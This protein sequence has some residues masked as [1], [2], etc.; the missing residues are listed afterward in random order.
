[1]FTI[2]ADRIGKR[3]NS[4]NVFKGLSF[5]ANTG[6]SIAV[7]GPNGS[8]KTTLLEII[9]GI[10]RPTVGEIKYRLDGEEIKRDVFPSL[11]GFSSPKINPYNELTGSENIQFALK[12]RK[13]ICTDA[14]LNR[15]LE[16]FNLKKEKNKS[17]RY[18]SSG[19]KQRLRLI[20]AVLHNPQILLLDEPGSNLDRLGKDI[21]YTYLD[22]VRSKKIIVI[23]TN[24]K[25][26]ANLCN[27]RL[28]LGQ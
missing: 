12:S 22:S 19:M 7:T 16:M 23:A 3:F 10:Q 26:E 8:G 5:T 11:L 6:S 25:E 9:A 24:E 18:Y 15:L 1:M 20:L 28:E 14:D 2:E 27:E 17:V 21:I 13:I 4:F